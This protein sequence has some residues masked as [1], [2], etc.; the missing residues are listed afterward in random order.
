MAPHA[1]ESE[2]VWTVL[3]ALAGLQRCGGSFKAGRGCAARESSRAQKVTVRAAVSGKSAQAARG[4]HAPG[5][6]LGGC[7]RGRWRGPGLCFSK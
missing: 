2:L 1:W 3:S 5:A 7:S 6:L 4:W